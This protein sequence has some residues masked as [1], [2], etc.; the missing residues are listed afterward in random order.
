MTITKKILNLSE[1][2][3]TAGMNISKVYISENDLESYKK[4]NGLSDLETV[5]TIYMCGRPLSVVI[6]N[7]TL[8]VQ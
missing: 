7:G 1:E 2:Q 8:T 4:E 3:V 6:N 5:K